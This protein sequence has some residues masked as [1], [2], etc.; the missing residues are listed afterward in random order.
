M[1]REKMIFLGCLLVASSAIAKPLTL[2]ERVMK[3]EKLL[4][5]QVEEHKKLQ[6]QLF[7]EGP[8]VEE[9]KNQE[10]T[11]DVTIVKRV[12][13]LEREAELWEVHGYAS[14]QYRVTDDGSSSGTNFGKG[15]FFLGLPGTGE[16]S[17]QVEL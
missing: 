3:L 1:I 16:S 10:K 9:D 6:C 4:E 12:S 14:L 7:E 15:D 11:D 5:V 17:N 13:K 8:I 2:E